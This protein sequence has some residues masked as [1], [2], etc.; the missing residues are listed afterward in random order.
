MIKL[1]YS[2]G[3]CSLAPHVV[4]E[5]IGAPYETEAVNLKAGEQRRPE[6]LARNPKGAVPALDTDHGVLT[7][8]VAIL[9]Y[10]AAIH[11]E[12]GL[13]PTGDA[14]AQAGLTSFL[15]FLSSSIH[16]NIGKLLFYPLDAEAKAAQREVTL[17]KMRLIEDSL[18]VGPW[19]LGETYSVADPYLMVFER[20]A[21][22]GGLLTAADFPRMNAHLDAVQARPA[23]ERALTQEGI[24]KV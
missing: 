10:L 24:A 18:L 19:A 22:S 1:Y 7:E 5:E 4:L 6:F 21:R 20:W 16:P 14:W 13:A 2:P 12:A 3:A 17:A 23:V 8:N 15:S 9:T 11:P